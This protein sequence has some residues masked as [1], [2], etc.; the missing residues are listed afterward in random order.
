MVAREASG[1]GRQRLRSV[2][3][4]LQ[5]D[6]SMR[7]KVGH[8]PQLRFH[9]SMKRNLHGAGLDGGVTYSEQAF[10][11]SRIDWAVQL[12]MVLTSGLIILLK[13]F[14]KASTSSQVVA[15]AECC[16]HTTRHPAHAAECKLQ[17]EKNQ[18]SQEA[19]NEASLLDTCRSRVG[20]MSL[21]CLH[22]SNRSWRAYSPVL[23]L[24]MQRSCHI[25]KLI[26]APAQLCVAEGIH[27]CG[28]PVS[29]QAVNGPQWKDVEL[30][31]V[32]AGQ[33][34]ANSISLDR[35]RR[36]CMLCEKQSR[37]PEKKPP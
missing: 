27:S 25:L 15:E 36:A 2:R 22:V 23:E 37:R 18:L 14:K 17:M 10:N 1:I 35:N 4:L 19:L 34:Q 8:G 7:A 6:I 13:S 30:L 33:G 3:A 31:R 32:Q 29:S 16:G 11:G 28:M 20:S 9:H 21:L 24:V 12:A 5:E 26:A